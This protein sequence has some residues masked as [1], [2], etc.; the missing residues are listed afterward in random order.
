MASEQEENGFCITPQVRNL[1]ECNDKDSI[2]NMQSL[3]NKLF[4]TYLFSESYWRMF[5]IK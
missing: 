5:F 4:F 3:K 2:L 1:K